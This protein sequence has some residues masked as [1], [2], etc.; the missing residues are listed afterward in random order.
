MKLALIVFFI[1]SFSF[2]NSQVEKAKIKK[3]SD[4][5]ECDDVEPFTLVEQQPEFPGGMSAMIQYIKKNLPLSNVT[6]RDLCH[7]T[8]FIK[9]TVTKDGDVSDVKVLKGYENCPDIE[10]MVVKAIESLPK[11][12]PGYVNGKPVNCYFNL[13]LRVHWG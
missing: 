10:K 3:E 7:G 13:P 9:F 12:K 2:L 5:I 1:L 11:F 8:I 6:C 4:A